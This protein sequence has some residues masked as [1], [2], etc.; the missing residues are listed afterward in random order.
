V[1]ATLARKQEAP[2]ITPGAV[3]RSGRDEEQPEEH[4]VAA[5]GLVGE[6][7]HDQRAGR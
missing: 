2:E 6:G 7:P 5:L 1:H 4:Q 3:D